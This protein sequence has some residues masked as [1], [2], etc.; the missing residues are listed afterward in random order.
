[1][2]KFCFIKEL[3]AT[4]R[5]CGYCVFLICQVK[6]FENVE[7]SLQEQR[8]KT[9]SPRSVDSNLTST[10]VIRYLDDDSLLLAVRSNCSWLEYVK[11]D[12]VLNKHLNSV[13]MKKRE[14]FLKMKTQNILK[15]PI[16]VSGT[17]ARNSQKV[18][19]RIPDDYLIHKDIYEAML[20]QK[21]KP[22]KSGGKVKSVKSNV[23]NKPYRL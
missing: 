1:M 3:T 20:T 21:T 2:K 16:P 9:M 22:K 8:I 23:R 10:A 4:A 12:S 14:D 13:L 19:V 6:S 15:R 7:L 11:G 5:V 18:V 17:F